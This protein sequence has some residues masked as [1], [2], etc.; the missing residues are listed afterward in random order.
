MEQ[1]FRVVLKYG[2]YTIYDGDKVIG[3]AMTED[4]AYEITNA[5]NG[6]ADNTLAHYADLV[7]KTTGTEIGT[8][9]SVIAAALG[10]AGEA[11]ECADHVKKYYFHNHAMQREKMI[12]ELGDLMWY[13]QLQCLNISVEMSEVMQSNTEKLLTGKNARYPEGFDSEKSK[14]RPVS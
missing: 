9:N 3:E 5:L 2:Q 7:R 4:R 6:I 13:V 11:G 10:I 14:N 12:E 8:P 1:R